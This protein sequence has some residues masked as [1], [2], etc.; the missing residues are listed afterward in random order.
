MR[1]S[2]LAI[3]LLTATPAFSQ[4]LLHIRKPVALQYKADSV[5]ASEQLAG[6][7]LTRVE[8]Y[9]PFIVA[10]APNGIDPSQLSKTLGMNVSVVPAGYTLDIAETH[11]DTRELLPE[12]PPEFAF[13]DYPVGGPGLYVVQ[14]TSTIRPEW[15]DALRRSGVRPIQFVN[16]NGYIVS[17]PAG[18]AALRKQLP[19]SAH[20]VMPLLPSLKVP[21]SLREAS[22]LS[23]TTPLPLTVIFDREASPADATTYL[24]SFDPGS[25]V[26][27]IAGGALRGWLTAGPATWST[28]AQSP[29]VLWIEPVSPAV[30]SDERAD[31]IAVGH[32]GTDLLP[33]SPGQY[34]AWL[35][36]R[37]GLSD[38]SSEIVDIMDS[39]IQTTLTSQSTCLTG[40]SMPGGHQDLNNAQNTS[41]L[42]YACPTCGQSNARDGYYHGTF[43]AAL[44]AGDPTQAGGTGLTDSNGFYWGMGLAPG[45]RFG[46]Q[47]IIADGGSVCGTMNLTANVSNAF[48][49]GARYQNNSW[50]FVDT[51]YTSMSQEYD[52]LVRDATGSFA[53]WANAMTVVFSAGNRTPTGT[54]PIYSPAT[55]KNVIS[56][57]ASGLPRAGLG[58]DC[59]TAISIRDIPSL[60]R[61]GF[62]PDSNVIKPDL[63]APGR[64]VTSARALGSGGQDC[65]N[66]T[67]TLPTTPNGPY[68]P[69]DGTSFSAPQ[70]TAAALLVKKTINA[71]PGAY[72]SPALIK[73][74][75]VGTAE[76]LNGGWDF[77]T[78][79]SV[80]WAPS[81]QTGFGR[82]SLAKL[83]ADSTPKVFIDED[84]SSPNPPNRFISSGGFKNYTFTVADPTKPIVGALVWT[85]APGNIGASTPRM[86]EIDMYVLQG[87]YVYC[88]GQTYQGY[89]QRSTGCWLPDFYNTVKRFVIAPNSFT[90]T[91][92]VQLVGSNITTHAVPGLDGTGPNQDWA[93]FLYNAY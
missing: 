27:R 49:R 18:L 93:L 81:R 66:S 8:D 87:S 75:L 58:G 2:V 37:P 76:Q 4:T 3:A 31:Q 25:E 88:D 91:F 28:L 10:T 64:S 33:T 50:N 42:A 41:R 22:R 39:G 67:A 30:L 9:G 57:G 61:R 46:V 23:D 92:T 36:S 40:S 62:A 80:P 16:T 79:S 51:T 68:Y 45:A 19:A 53:S 78:N 77:V 26:V 52:Y 34:K 20:F 48:S 6:Y 29:G 63:L 56:V 11:I 55:A 73:A 47:K 32:Y 5:T 43:V 83:L 1:L 70:V 71:T 82:L 69:G 59:D 21:K 60:S 86:N 14:F 90:G 12:T 24:R 72:V 38:L 54:T 65:S 84:H 85:D 15:L 13:V 74:T 7:G 44:I 35:A 89:S 17:A